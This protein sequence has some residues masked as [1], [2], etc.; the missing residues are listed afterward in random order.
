M[1]Y[2]VILMINFFLINEIIFAFGNF[3]N[4]QSNK[5]QIKLSKSFSDNYWTHSHNIDQTLTV[6]YA[7]F[8]NIDICIL[9][10]LN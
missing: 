10:K 1:Y 4:L 7:F 3:L 9:F 5:L 8:S 2:L 6:S